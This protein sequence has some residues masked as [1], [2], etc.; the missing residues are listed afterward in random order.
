[1]Y[2]AVMIVGGLLGGILSLHKGRNPFLWT[3]LCGIVPLVLLILLALPRLPRQGVWRPCPFCL[4]IIPWQAGVCS[5]C[6]REV[7]P[8]HWE[9]C[10]YCQNIV[11]AGQQRCAA[12]GNPAPWEERR[13]AS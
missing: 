6:R 12:C 1:M 7:P 5:Y 4:R 10:R 11:W 3:V 9:R 13:S 2:L 8:P